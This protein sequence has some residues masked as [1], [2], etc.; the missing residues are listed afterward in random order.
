MS[1]CLWFR[2]MDFLAPT[3]SG[4]LNSPSTR[5]VGIRGAPSLSTVPHKHTRAHTCT[6]TLS[7]HPLGL[8][9]HIPLQTPFASVQQVH[10]KQRFAHRDPAGSDPTHRLWLHGQQCP[11]GVRRRLSA[12]GRW[13]PLPGSPQGE[14]EGIR[15]EK[16]QREGRGVRALAPRFVC[17]WG[18]SCTGA[19]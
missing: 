1:H 18:G 15:K 16:E 6:P 3:R 4:C 19:V 2:R 10:L 12:P 8:T 11:V 5:C 9:G 17:V 7:A 14:E 13:Q